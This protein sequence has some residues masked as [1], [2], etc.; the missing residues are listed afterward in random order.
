V[1]VVPGRL[2]GDV[3]AGLLIELAHAARELQTQADAAARGDGW[4]REPLLRLDGSRALLCQLGWEREYPQEDVG[5]DM[6]EHAW[7]LL[8]AI[9]AA[10][11]RQREALARERPCGRGA[12]RRALKRRVLALREL[13][14]SVEAWAARATAATSWRAAAPAAPLQCGHRRRAGPPF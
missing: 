11:R 1:F 5:V 2:V 4:Q 7:A 6:R 13:L 14:F 8:T 3:R 9:A 12:G 10:H